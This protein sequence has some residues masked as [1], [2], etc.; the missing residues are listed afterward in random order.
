MNAALPRLRGDALPT[1]KLEF[2]P[3]EEKAAMRGRSRTS[4]HMADSC[5]ADVEALKMNLENIVPP[6]APLKD[7]SLLY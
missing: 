3:K 1:F 2:Y 6:E 4:R 7:G 5:A